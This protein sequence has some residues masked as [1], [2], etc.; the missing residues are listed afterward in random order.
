ME[1]H[2]GRLDERIPELLESEDL[3]HLEVVLVD[4]LNRDVDCL[5]SLLELDA[6]FVDSIYN[7]FSALR[8]E[9]ELD[10]LCINKISFGTL[11]NE[12]NKQ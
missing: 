12:R 8:K 10:S 1:D 11:S 6:H 2:L 4:Q 9:V 5:S 7:S 3:A